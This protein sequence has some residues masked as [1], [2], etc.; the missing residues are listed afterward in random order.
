MSAP[1]LQGHITG[2]DD[3]HHAVAEVSEMHHQVP[4]SL[5]CSGRLIAIFA[6]SSN[7][8]MLPKQLLHFP[9]GDSMGCDVLD[10]P[11]IPEKDG[12]LH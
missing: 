2:S 11:V 7:L 1:F 3:P 10:V 8:W 5:S 12:N 6:G 9:P 4:P